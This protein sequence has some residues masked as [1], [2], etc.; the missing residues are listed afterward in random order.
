M[1]TGAD[2]KGITNAEV[3]L[4]GSTRC[5][6]MVQ[7]TL[8]EIKH[9]LAGNKAYLGHCSARKRPVREANYTDKWVRLH[10]ILVVT[11]KEFAKIFNEADK[12]HDSRSRQAHEK[13]DFEQ[14]HK[15]QHNDLQWI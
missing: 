12:Y 3:P 6:L 5:H 2:L 9:I 14:S 11:V 15:E 13:G 4:Y 8:C 10:R 1:R 7:G